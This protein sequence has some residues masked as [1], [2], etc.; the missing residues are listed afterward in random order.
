[1]V[2]KRISLAKLKEQLAQE[3]SKA[4]TSS[5]RMEIQRELRVL[6]EGEGSKLARR[7]GRGFVVLVGKGARATGRGIVRARKFAEES[8]AGEGLDIRLER[9]IPS[10]RPVR[11]II[12]RRIIR[13]AIPKAVRRKIIRRKVAR[14]IAPRVVRRVVRR[15]IK[16]RGRDLT[17]RDNAFA[18][19]DF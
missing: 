7:F 1:M 18:P 17:G 4:K 16:K 3:R 6:R 8:G 13:R 10:E 12:R 15:R 19:L 5:E 9:S 2:K 11:R 14:R